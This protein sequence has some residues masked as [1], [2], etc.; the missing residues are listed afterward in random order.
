M[1]DYN[2]YMP[3]DIRLFMEDNPVHTFIYLTGNTKALEKAEEIIM[4]LDKTGIEPE[5]QTY[6]IKPDEIRSGVDGENRWF[7]IVFDNHVPQICE[8]LKA[9]NGIEKVLF[10]VTP[11]LINV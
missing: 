7:V 9:A 5:G 8:K 4:A 2:S 11:H 3:D 10:V 1:N 6:I